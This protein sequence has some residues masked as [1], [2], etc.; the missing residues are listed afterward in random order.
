MKRQRAKNFQ[1]GKK[2][3]TA[4]PLGIKKHK[5]KGGNGL[6]E[7]GGHLQKKPW[8]RNYRHTKKGVRGW[9]FFYTFLRR[10]G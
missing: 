10:G 1:G 7:I 9:T 2:T 6:G 5:E 8:V 3:G 4:V